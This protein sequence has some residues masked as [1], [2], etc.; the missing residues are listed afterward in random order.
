[1]NVFISF[2]VDQTKIYPQYGL[3]YEEDNILISCISATSVIWYFNGEAQDFTKHTK[4]TNKLQLSNVKHNY[5]GFYE[6]QGIT[7]DGLKFAAYSKIKVAGKTNDGK[8]LVYNCNV[9]L[10]KN[11]STDQICSPN[12][13]IA[14][15][16]E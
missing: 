14:F 10:L 5:S 1:M 2:T 9:K 3:V 12:Y 15:T 7:Y 11:S 6:C 8:I 13:G 4:Y 16:I